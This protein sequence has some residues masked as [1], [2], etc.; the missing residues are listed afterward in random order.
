MRCMLRQVYML[1]AVRIA[2]MEWEGHAGVGLIH[3]MLLV[4]Q[5]P[6]RSKSA[7]LPGSGL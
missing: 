3:D 6:C 1:N 5:G 4:A 2:R 7:R